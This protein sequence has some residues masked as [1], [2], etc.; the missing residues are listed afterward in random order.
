MGISTGD[1]IRALSAHMVLGRKCV[2][3]AS[4]IRMMFKKKKKKTIPQNFWMSSVIKVNLKGKS[5]CA[6]L[7]LSVLDFKSKDKHM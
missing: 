4:L 6:N 3:K 5:K 2:Y 1:N 7:P